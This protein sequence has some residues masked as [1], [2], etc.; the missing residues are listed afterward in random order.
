MW[1]LAK[2]NLFLM[3]MFAFLA[4]MPAVSEE[5]ATE[6][7]DVL[8]EMEAKAAEIE[9]TKKRCKALMQCASYAKRKELKDDEMRLYDEV[10]S[11]D[12]F[13]KNAH[14]K[15]GDVHYQKRIWMTEDEFEDFE[16]TLKEEK[17]NPGFQK[18]VQAIETESTTVAWEMFVNFSEKSVAWKVEVAFD[19]YIKSNSQNVRMA[20]IK[21][22]GDTYGERARD[23]M[24]DVVKRKLNE[25]TLLALD[26]LQLNV[27]AGD[28]YTNEYLWKIYKKY[29]N[30]MV[31]Q[32]LLKVLQ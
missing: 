18:M 7:A 9:D 5:K 16:A 28:E 22:L 23:C 31:Q 3:V 19:L 21:V 4:S 32:K 11:L 20:A 10:I 2:K 17:E 13:H 30:S 27:A 8:A 14:K 29:N 25:D 1:L 15:R 26:Y 6:P 24:I 12:M